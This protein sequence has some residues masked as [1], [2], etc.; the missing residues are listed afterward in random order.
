MHQNFVSS[1]NYRQ[2]STPQASPNVL[3]INPVKLLNQGFELDSCNGFITA[4]LTAAAGVAG[5]GYSMQVDTSKIN[6]D[7]HVISY[8]F[9]L[10]SVK[11]PIVA[12]GIYD[13]DVVHGYVDANV[14]YYPISL[15]SCAIGANICHCSGTGAITVDVSPVGSATNLTFAALCFYFRDITAGPMD[16]FYSLNHVLSDVQFFQPLK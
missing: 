4:T 15:D 3:P 11:P 14:R 7:N 1:H 8:A 6:M 12:I 9:N 2:S 13:A 5:V 10:T 16:G